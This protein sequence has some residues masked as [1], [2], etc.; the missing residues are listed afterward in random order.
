MKTYA[1]VAA[2]AAMFLLLVSAVPAEA[3]GHSGGRGGHVGSRHFSG[4]SRVVVGVG[5]GSPSWWGP[6]YY[7]SYYPGYYSPPAVVQQAPPA[8]IQQTPA[9]PNF[10]YYCQ[11][12]EGY[13]PYVQSC[14][15]GWTTV[16]PSG[17][18]AQ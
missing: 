4:H 18:P 8:Y 10:W 1:G 11:A 9:A 16:S 2:L 5:V 7:Y 6:P 17:Y 15:G 12:P 14:P 13:Y 3:R